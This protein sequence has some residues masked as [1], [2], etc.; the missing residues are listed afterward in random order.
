M[1]IRMNQSRGNALRRGSSDA[2]LMGAVVCFAVVAAG[3]FFVYRQAAMQ[4]QQ[5]AAV[6]EVQKAKAA[7]VTARERAGLEVEQAEQSAKVESV[8]S[9]ALEVPVVTDA[10]TPNDTIA[11]VDSD[12]AVNAETK[13]D[14]AAD[15]RKQILAHLEFGEF[16]RAFELAR[17]ADDRDEKSQLFGLVADA[18]MSIGD[19]GA[20]LGSIRTMPDYGE[21]LIARS[22][23][24]QQQALAGGAQADFTQLIALIMSETEGLWEEDDGQGGTISEFEQGVRVDPSGV[25]EK[26][27]VAEQSDRL[28]QLG[29]QARE[30]LLND[31][32]ATVSDMRVVSLTRLERAV[33]GRLSEGKQPTR[34]MQLMGGL[35]QIQ[36][37]FVYPEDGEIVLTGPAEAWKYNANGIPVGVDSGRPVL[38]LDDFVTVLRSLSPNTDR[39]FSCS[40][41]PRPEG[42]KRLKTF[43]AQSGSRPLSGPAA[44][45]RWAGNLQ[46]QLGRQDIVYKGIDPESRVARIIVEADYRM[47]LIGIGKYE[48]TGTSRI[49]SIFDLMTRE[50]QTASKHDAL[51][52][53]LTMKYDAVLHTPDQT[54]YEFVGS[55]VLCRSEDQFINDQAQQVQTGK[56]TGSNRLFAETFTSKY[57]TLA[58]QDLVFADLKNVFDL[59][60]V[61]S[62]LRQ[63]NAAGQADW[64]FGAFATDGPYMTVRHE[65]ATEVDSVVNHRTYRGKDIVVQVAGGVRVDLAAVLDNDKIRREGKRLEASI[66]KA[67]RS[68]DLP[69]RRWWWDA[70]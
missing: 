35:T 23:H 13:Q 37:L 9:A 5:A 10:A 65:A 57:D 68:T 60:L 17:N 28:K 33:A 59:S 19:F 15:R 26:L 2:V 54:G 36:H 20:A 44:V 64:D 51:R 32:I 58:K 42:L 48:F 45:R 38:Q 14:S 43:M 22:N 31:D 41:N 67:E 27:T 56:S 53:W 70:R 62:I 69:N 7:E 24:N 8:D 39:Y 30:A 29:L 1:Q 25:L 12:D 49:P 63:E 55:S 18:Q 66:A 52:W 16:E 11:V 3:G 21:R 61:A 6:A 50:E 47:K 46:E 4:N 34:S 40:I